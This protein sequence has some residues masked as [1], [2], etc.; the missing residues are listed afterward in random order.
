[1]C[2]NCK[3]NYVTVVYV[4]LITKVDP[5]NGKVCMVEVISITVQLPKGHE[6]IV[7]ILVVERF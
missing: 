3:K 4:S 1:M 7:K 2:E 5:I 6:L